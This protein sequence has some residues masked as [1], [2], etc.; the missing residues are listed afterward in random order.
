MRSNQKRTNAGCFDIKHALGGLIDIEFMVQYW[1][2]AGAALQPGLLEVRHTDDLLNGLCQAG[3]ITA[4][5]YQVLHR[6]YW[7]YSDS[8][9]QQLL[10]NKPAQVDLTRVESIASSVCTIWQETFGGNDER[11]SEATGLYRE[12]NSNQTR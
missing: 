3:C 12:S 10:Q 9:N 5:A 7:Q 8:I 11:E 4:H 2:L 6:A 1:V